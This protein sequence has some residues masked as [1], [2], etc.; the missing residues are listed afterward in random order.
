MDYPHTTHAT[1][2]KVTTLTQEQLTSFILN[3]P[4]RDGNQI[5]G[6]D[7]DILLTGWRLIA[8]VIFTNGLNHRDCVTLANPKT[9]KT[10]P[11]NMFWEEPWDGTVA[12]IQDLYERMQG[13]AG[14]FIGQPQL[15]LAGTMIPGGGMGYRVISL[16]RIW[17]TEGGY[18]EPANMVAV[19]PTLV[20]RIDR[21]DSGNINAGYHDWMD[22][23][24]QAHADQGGSK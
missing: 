13:E 10:N 18:I 12:H 23:L 22:A 14:A 24:D 11:D 21:T 15:S 9:P 1:R 5:G 3:L 16:E 2:L 6:D 20:E 4:P 17:E 19:V 8:Q 7:P